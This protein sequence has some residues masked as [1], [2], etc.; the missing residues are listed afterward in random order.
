MKQRRMF[1]MTKREMLEAVANGT[2]TEEVQAMAAAELE[3]LDA[4]N[5]AKRIKAAEKRA[6][7]SKEDA[8][9]VEALRAV[10]SETP[11]SAAQLL[12]ESGLEIT[13]NKVSVLMRPL[14]EAGTV[15]KTKVKSSN[16]KGQLVGYKLA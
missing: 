1:K 12:E 10:L 9:L 16:G 14:V 15:E 6:E 4:A 5:E 7:K 2:I 13:R 3:K 8:A 11:K